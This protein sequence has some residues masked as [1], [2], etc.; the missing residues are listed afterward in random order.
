MLKLTLKVL[1]YPCLKN[2][3]NFPNIALGIDDLTIIGIAPFEGDTLLTIG[4]TKF[5]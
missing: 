3:R 4:N 5:H 1:I 2:I